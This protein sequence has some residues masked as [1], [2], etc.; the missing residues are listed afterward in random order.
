MPLS[1]Q[2]ALITSSQRGRCSTT[3]RQ[4]AAAGAFV[5]ICGRNAAQGTETVTEI[6]RSGGRAS[7]VLT[8]IATHSDV[9]AA[10]DE[11]I[12]TYGRLDILFNHASSSRECDRALSQVSENAWDRITEAMLK[13]TFF[14]CQY[15]LPFL[16]NA[17]SG[18]IINLV[19]RDGPTQH[20]AASSICQGG[21]VALTQS[22]S[23]QYS[24]GSVV[25]NLI[26]SAPDVLS[27]PTLF[28]QNVLHGPSLSAVDPASDSAS[29]SAS[30][31]ADTSEAIMYLATDPHR[32]QG[33]TLAVQSL[34]DT[35]SCL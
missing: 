4:L 20:Y 24:N 26:V 8:D 13:G 17:D 35:D 3:A 29:R 9:Q 23:Q 14:C 15:A 22:I 11:T 16:Q 18:R 21:L 30:D 10:I 25:A 27:V 32:L 2:V 1:N 12:A 19:E 33:Y 7:F 6:Q 31:F 34:S 28:T 5:M